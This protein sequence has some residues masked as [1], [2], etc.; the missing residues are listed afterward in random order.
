MC[1]LVAFP[2]NFPKKKALAIIEEFSFGNNDGTGSVYIKDEKFIV[3]KWP[4]SFREVIDRRLP[5]LDH[6]PHNGW[7]IAHVRAISHGGKSMSNTHP[8]IHNNWAMAHNGIFSEY[9]PVKAVLQK[10]LRVDFKGHTDSEV[11]LQL[12]EH[13]GKEQFIKS[14]SSGVFMFLNKLGQLDV[15]CCSGGDLVFKK[16]KWGVVLASELNYNTYKRAH[17]VLEGTF[18]LSKKGTFIHANWE[19]DAG[20]N[21]G[22][23]SPNWPNSYSSWHSEDDLDLERKPKK[24]YHWGN[25][26]LAYD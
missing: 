15:I 14:M 3:N 25:N 19:K 1:R 5:L 9:A 18:K 17:T 7:T 23:T 12:W 2:P 8:F 20:A 21:W 11:A 10:A 13:I 16:T 22:Y 4:L 6:M 26:H 24:A